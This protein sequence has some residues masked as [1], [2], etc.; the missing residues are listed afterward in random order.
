MPTGKL[1]K[2]EDEQNKTKQKKKYFRHVLKN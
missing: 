2:I 1:F